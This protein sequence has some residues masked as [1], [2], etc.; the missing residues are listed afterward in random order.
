M[1]VE[2]KKLVSH[3]QDGLGRDQMTWD[4]W[5]YD[6]EG[7]PA[8]GVVQKMILEGTMLQNY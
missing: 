6:V 2:E 1:T 5:G 7:G 8:T 3:W 4:V